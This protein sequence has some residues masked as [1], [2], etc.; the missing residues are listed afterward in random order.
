MAN[1]RQKK[2]ARE[3][4]MAQISSNNNTNMGESFFASVLK[5]SWFSKMSCSRN[6]SHISC[7]SDRSPG[8]QTP[9]PVEVSEN[10]RSNR[11]RNSFVYKD[12]QMILQLGSVVKNVEEEEKEEE[13]QIE[14]G[15]IHNM[16]RIVTSGD[17]DKETTPLHMITERGSKTSSCPDGM[18]EPNDNDD[19]EENHPQRL[20]RCGSKAIDGS[21]KGETSYSISGS[22][23]NIDDND[24]GEDITPSFKYTGLDDD[25]VAVEDFL[26][27]IFKA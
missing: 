17:G 21:E 10:V 7:D 18:C 27:E 15:M 3:E 13:K 25:K 4:R 2:R 6:K 16:K 26:Q 9:T 1:E 24:S 19:E 14:H 20:K 12:G 11:R 23:S 5:H 22:F 8:M